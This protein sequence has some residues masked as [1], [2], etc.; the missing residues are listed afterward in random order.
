MVFYY[1]ETSS[2]NTIFFFAIIGTTA[3]KR[4]GGIFYTELTLRKWGSKEWLRAMSRVKCTHT[5]YRR[6]RMICNQN[7]LYTIAADPLQPA[8]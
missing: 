6:A 1:P 8:I 4:Y 2:Q 3:L 5:V 7:M